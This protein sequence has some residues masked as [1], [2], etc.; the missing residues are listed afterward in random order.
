MN[1]VYTS[2]L[3]LLVLLGTYGLYKYF[4]E[5]M[6]LISI[7]DNKDPLQMPDSDL[8]K[9]GL[10]APVQNVDTRG[11]PQNIV[12]DSYNPKPLNESESEYPKIL[13][14]VPLEYLQPADKVNDF[15]TVFNIG[16]GNSA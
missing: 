6:T 4:F 1:L 14:N 15:N 5:S 13:G 16:M 11:L 9:K 10:E 2:L 12:Q 8:V 3:I 7:N